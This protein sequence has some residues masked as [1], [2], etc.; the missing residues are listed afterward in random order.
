MFAYVGCRTTKERGARGTGISVY[1][2]DAACNSWRHVE[3]IGPL[4]NPSYLV[5]DASQRFLYAVHGD[6]GEASAF[7][8]DESTGQ[9]THLNTVACGGL[10][11]VHLAFDASGHFMLIANFKTG[12]VATLNVLSDGRL[13]DIAHIARVTGTVGPRTDQQKG[14]HPHQVVWAPD[15]QTVIVPDKGV[16]QIS[17]FEFDA[18]T[19]ALDGLRP[20]HTTAGAAPR[21]IAFHPSQKWAYLANELDSTM[22]A[23]RWHAH[24]RT[25]ELLQCLPTVQEG[26]AEN[27]STAGIVV[28]PSGRHVIISNRGD[29]TVAMFAIDQSS[30]QLTFR[31]RLSTGGTQPRF[32]SLA[33]AGR[34]LLVANETSDRIVELE[35]DDERGR[36]TATGRSISTPS[37]TCIAFKTAERR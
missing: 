19:G 30:G 31:Q 8:I 37:P 10:N 5:L 32:I 27:N 13:G 3:T 18:A 25:F 20:V 4:I 24:S 9:L 34:T 35:I 29:D 15:R 23:Y 16:D 17:L 7:A 2:I 33:P 12:S 6:R 21:H 36:M 11:P 28:T 22:A 26:A 14:A 1:S